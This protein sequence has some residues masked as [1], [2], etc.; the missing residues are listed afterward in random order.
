MQ[1]LAMKY[2]KQKTMTC[3]TRCLKEN[4]PVSHERSCVHSHH[5]MK[6][7]PKNLFIPYVIIVP[8][9]LK[10]LEWHVNGVGEKDWEDVTGRHAKGDAT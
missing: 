5:F 4:I 3:L 7:L 9:S 2:K 8:Q 1:V 10:I 6:P